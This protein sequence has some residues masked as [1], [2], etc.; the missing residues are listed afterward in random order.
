MRAG[1]PRAGE[2]VPRARGRGPPAGCCALHSR[3]WLHGGAV[4]K[5]RA[6]RQRNGS[7]RAPVWGAP[8]TRSAVRGEGASVRPDCGPASRATGGECMAVA[9]AWQCTGACRREAGACGVGRHVHCMR[10][11]VLQQRAR[12]NCMLAVTVRLGAYKT[13]VI[14][15]IQT[16]LDKPLPGAEAGVKGN[17][18][19]PA[20]QLCCRARRTS[21][22]RA[23]APHCSAC[24][25]LRAPLGPLGPWGLLFKQRPSC[26]LS[27]SA[28]PE[29]TVAL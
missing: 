9:G 10:Q 17:R 2:A 24:H 29:E 21:R 4:A 5:R 6:R 28:L 27:S 11:R 8:P 15:R 3:R 12:A 22:K 25:P 13:C 20:A 14:K 19:R 1:R 18:P 16:H 7:R 26:C 23:K